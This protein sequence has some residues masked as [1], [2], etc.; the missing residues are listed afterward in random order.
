MNTVLEQLVVSNFN[1]FRDVKISPRK[2]S[3]PA[4]VGP[5]NLMGRCGSDRYTHS[6][7]WI[8]WDGFPLCS[9]EAHL[10]CTAK[11]EGSVSLSGRPLSL[12]SL[13]L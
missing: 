13:R 4:L 7:V 5:G 10:L 6:E 11:E 8:R 9:Q 3:Y 12:S 2:F 1:D